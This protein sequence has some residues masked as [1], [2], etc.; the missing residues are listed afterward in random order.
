MKNTNQKNMTQDERIGKIFG[1]KDIV[2][3][4][5]PND[6]KIPEVDDDSLNIYFDFLEQNIS[7]CEVTGRESMGYFGWEERF[8]FHGKD[9]S[10]EKLAKERGSMDDIYLLINIVDYED[11]EVGLLANVKRIN[12][13]K[14]FIIPLQDLECK[15]ESDEFYDTIDDYASWFVNYYYG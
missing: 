5:D 2:E 9:S 13:N 15:K 11:I 12:D 8:A 10:Y 4:D 1:I 3:Y 7:K 14:K 6:P